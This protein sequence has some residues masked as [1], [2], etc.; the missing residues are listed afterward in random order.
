MRCSSRSF[1]RV[2]YSGS[3]S[4]VSRF[5]YSQT[6]SR[7]YD[8]ED[9]V[10][11]SYSSTV[12][13]RRTNNEAITFDHLLHLLLR[14]QFVAE[15]DRGRSTDREQQ[16]FFHHRFLCAASAAAPRALL[17][18]S[19]ARCTSCAASPAAAPCVSCAITLL[20]SILLQRPAKRRRATRPR[21]VAVPHAVLS[22]TCC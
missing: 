21:S 4:G 2:F 17:V 6:T 15:K 13:P 18:L 19:R 5:S 10:D 8:H 20:A 3:G 9:V 11:C 14:K 12:G 1:A 16:Q 7:H 22:Q